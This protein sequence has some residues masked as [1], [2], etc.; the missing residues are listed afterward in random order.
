MVDSN[1]RI[2]VKAEGW[3]PEGIDRTLRALVACEAHVVGVGTKEGALVED[4]CF[5]VLVTAGDPGFVRF[6]I[7][8]QGYAE[9]VDTTEELRR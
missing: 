7:E 4:G 9:I 8:R 2:L 1:R 6:A 5:I 3:C